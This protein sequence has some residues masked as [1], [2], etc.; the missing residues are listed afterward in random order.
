MENQTITIE[1]LSLDQLKSLLFILIECEKMK[2]YNVYK[3]EETNELLHI[4]I[5][6][7]SIK[8]EKKLKN[9]IP[10]KRK[11]KYSFRMKHT[12]I[13]SF[14]TIFEQDLVVDFLGSFEQTIIMHLM[15]QYDRWKKNKVEFLNQEYL[16][17]SN[18]IKIS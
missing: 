5:S 13:C 8:L 10:K 12:E 9:L 6:E 2:W 18:L 1:S 4:T 14:I 7:L 17:D 16:L 3:S 11:K 15:H